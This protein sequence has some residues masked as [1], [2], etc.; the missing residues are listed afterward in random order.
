MRPRDVPV[1]IDHLND[2]PAEL[3][4]GARKLGGAAARTFLMAHT[5][6]DCWPLLD[7]FV[8]DVVVGGQSAGT[9]LLGQ[10]VVPDFSLADLLTVYPAELWVPVGGPP[11]RRIVPDPDEWRDN[12]A[13]VGAPARVLPDADYRFDSPPHSTALGNVATEG[14]VDPSAAL[15]RWIAA[16]LAQVVRDERAL[17]S[18]GETPALPPVAE[19]SECAH[20][21][22]RALRREYREAGPPA[23]SIPGM[24]GPDDWYA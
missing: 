2:M 14:G 21:A 5:T 16:R 10:V 8:E 18:I 12:V 22:A 1:T 4:E 13:W 6:P 9:W 20:R 17:D 19:W 24:R 23:D 15:C 7:L 11:T 3:V